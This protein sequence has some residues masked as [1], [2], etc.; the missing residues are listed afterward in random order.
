MRKL[1]VVLTSAE[2]P[3]L[4]STVGEEMM[5]RSLDV[6]I[7]DS[8][9]T[10]FSSISLSYCVTRLCYL[11]LFA[12]YIVAGAC[13]A[14]LSDQKLHRSK[15]MHASRGSREYVYLQAWQSHLALVH[16]TPPVGSFVDQALNAID[17]S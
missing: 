8:W 3:L 10:F 4:Q 14:Y 11:Y 2:T 13:F 16:T 1:P 15:P 12:G 7:Y 17:F 6:F 5:M 9:L